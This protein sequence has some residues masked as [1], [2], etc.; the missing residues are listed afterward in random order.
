MAAPRER[1]HELV[2]RRIEADLSEGR[3]SLGDRL[4]GERGMAE[5]LGVSRASVREA[6]RV[7]EAMGIVLEDRPGGATEWRKK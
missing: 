4:P 6:I 5:N 3:V 2:L 7:L 1:T